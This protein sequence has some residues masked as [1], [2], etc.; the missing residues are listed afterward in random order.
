MSQAESTR[1]EHLVMNPRFFKNL[2]TI[3]CDVHGE[4]TISKD[5]VFEW[6]KKFSRFSEGKV[7]VEGNQ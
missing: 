2:W 1:Y 7:D 6:H 5:H 4:H 3:V